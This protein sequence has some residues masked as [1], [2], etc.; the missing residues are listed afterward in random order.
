[1][2]GG[3]EDGRYGLVEDGTVAS[4]AAEDGDVHP[5]KVERSWKIPINQFFV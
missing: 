1:M 4:E 2:W 3:R 5:L